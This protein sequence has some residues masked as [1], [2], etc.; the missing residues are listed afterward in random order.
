MINGMRQLPTATDNFNTLISLRFSSRNRSRRRHCRSRLGSPPPET[1]TCRLV[2]YRT[3]DALAGMDCRLL[4]ADGPRS[5]SV[6]VRPQ[7][8]RLRACFRRS[9]WSLLLLW[10]LLALLLDRWPAA[11]AMRPGRVQE[12]RQETVEMFYHGFD[13]YMKIAF[14]EDEV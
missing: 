11:A 8:R 2:C 1:N 7:L 9:S 5:E 13:N 12:L 14:P 3:G 10:I 6:N 4:A